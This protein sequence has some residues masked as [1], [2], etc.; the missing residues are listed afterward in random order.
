MRLMLSSVERLAVYSDGLA[1]LDGKMNTPLEDAHL[2]KIIQ[3][4]GESPTSDDIS[5]FEI[6][7]SAART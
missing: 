5:F 7:L 6:Q 3:T 2:N 1:V 4:V